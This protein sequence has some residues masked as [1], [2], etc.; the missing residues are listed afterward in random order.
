MEYD[1]L[2]LFVNQLNNRL[3][4]TSL[5]FKR[6]LYY[7][8]DWR[9]R[10]I[11]IKGS[12]GVGKTTL[13]LQHIKE[14]FAHN[15]QQV[16]FASLDDIWFRGHSLIDL[17]EY[18]S[19]HNYTHLF[20]DEVHKYPDW[21]VVIKTI[22]DSYPSLHI[23]Y[24][25]SSMLEIDNSKSD[26]S[27]RQT[28]YMLPGLSFR[29]FVE[30]EGVLKMEPLT[31]EQILSSHQSVAMEVTS[32]IKVL[33]YFER[34]LRVGCFP[35]YKETFSEDEYYGKIRAMINLVVE[36]DMPAV[37]DVSYSTVQKT[38]QLL[39]A[40]APN[41][42][43]VPNISKLSQQL[44]TNSPQCLKLLY[45]LDRANIIRVLS[46]Q[47]KNYKYLS[48]PDKILLNNSN[49]LCA[50]TARAD[51]GTC[52]ESFMVH[53]LATQGEVAVAS[54][55]DFLFKDTYL[56]EVGGRG[57]DYSQIADVENSFFAVADTEVGIG[58]R[59]PLWMFGLLY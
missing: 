48:K 33:T 28:L 26:L 2:L 1:D 24:T 23:V 54:K 35:F 17:A 31:L 55:G 32:K 12:R 49:L 34:Y 8:I 3:K 56:F 6:F 44:E 42:P 29:E 16:F 53:Q 18:L 58:S 22:Y 11:G 41:V 43:L 45:T 13:L 46:N 39:M 10:L 20:L 9:P 52:R 19:T 51:V 21:S 30:F 25:G 36:T 15:I 38:R 37:E 50:L 47:Q 4:A 7:D 27:R 57:K 14:S 59:I 40:I 5:T